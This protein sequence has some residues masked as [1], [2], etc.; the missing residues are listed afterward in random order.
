MK[1]SHVHF[2]SVLLAAALD[3]P[4]DPLPAPIAINPLFVLHGE[5]PSGER[6]DVLPPLGIAIGR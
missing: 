6:R 2:G 3:E 5:P 4:V 1:G